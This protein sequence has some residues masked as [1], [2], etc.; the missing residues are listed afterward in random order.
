MKSYDVPFTIMFTSQ[1]IFSKNIVV[2]NPI[3]AYE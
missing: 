2:Q 1:K 3:T